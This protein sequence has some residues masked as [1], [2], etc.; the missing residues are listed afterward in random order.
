M[1]D[2]FLEEL[3]GVSAASIADARDERHVVLANAFLVAERA[4]LETRSADV[5]TA[6]ATLHHGG[7]D[8][9]EP[10]VARA[11]ESALEMA[12]LL[13]EGKYA[14][15]VRSE[16][17]LWL[18]EALAQR[19]SG[20]GAATS[21]DST[22][23]HL[24][25]TVAHALEQQLLQEEDGDSRLGAAYE[26][27]FVG[28]AL[29]SMYV[30]ANYT[31]PAFEPEQLHDIHALAA[32]FFAA[33]TSP[34]ADDVAAEKKLHS[35]ALVALQVD[36][37][38]PFA[39]CEYPQFLLLGRCLLHVVGNATHRNWSFAVGEA[40]NDSAAQDV[41]SSPSVGPEVLAVVSQLH[42]ASW[43]NARA[44]V[45][46]ERL[47]LTKE[48]SNTLWFEARR[49]FRRA[50]RQSALFATTET[51][52]YL[53]VRLEV[54][55]GLAQHH[56]DKN[57]QGK[58]SFE[59]AKELSGVSVQLSGSMGKRT[60]FQQKST[61]Q[62]VLLAASK[63]PPTDGAPSV[64]ATA[65][66]AS[67]HADFG[68]KQEPQVDDGLDGDGLTAAERELQRLVATGEASY[69]A[70]SL[71]QVDQDNILHEHIAF[72]DASLTAQGNLQVV[73]QVLLLALCL[74]VKNSNAND[75]LTREEMVPYVTRVLE[76][77]N[78]WMVYSTALLERAW[79]ECETSKRRERA[80]LQMQALVD[81][82]T[83]R[84]T[85]TQNSLAAIADAAP[86][87]ERL[88]FV[89]ALAFPPRYAL[90][91]DLAER[92]LAI[93]VVQSAL[94]IFESLEMW[95]DVV[96]CYQLL[97]KPL[98]AEK[99][100]R[101][102]LTV[103]PTPYMWCCLGDVTRDVTHYETAWTLS[104]H[105]FARAKRSLGRHCFEAGEYDAA[106]AHYQASVDV[107]PMHTS[108]WFVL[109]TMGMR[110]ERWSLAL[111]AFTRVAQLDP[112][113]G[114]AWGNIGSIHMHHGRYVDAFAVLQEALKQKRYMWQMWENYAVCAME[115]H[116]YGEAI[117]A[118]HQ[119]LDL[120]EKHARPVDHEVLAWLVEAIVFPEKYDRLVEDLRDAAS[121]SGENE[122]ENEDENENEDDDDLGD[123]DEATV[124]P[125]RTP[126]RSNVNL[127][128][129]LALLLGRITSIT[130]TNA[131]VWQ[132]Y[133]HFNDGLGR[134]E[135]AL[136]CR[137][138]QC[139]ALQKA[140]WEQDEA[141]VRELSKAA[142]RLA[143]DYVR[144]GSKKSLYACRLYL[145]GVLKKAQVDYAALEDVQA[146]AATLERVTGMEVEA[147]QR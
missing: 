118:L 92:Y 26:V 144:E 115:T 20:G 127:K 91:R 139:R 85:I 68:G 89:H 32:R 105:R 146:L 38:S 16:R 131:K 6:V 124:A 47:L 60:K 142:G 2:D 114:E 102:R 17:G 100:I 120:R 138:K 33:S 62:L 135:K 134:S 34:T 110:L 11:A 112:E 82:H 63:L 66:A 42:S 70:I 93:G 31:G 15:I 37:E 30:Q 122:V 78:N 123:L 51:A 56:F 80:L 25:T 130:T 52:A 64:Y 69:R 133:A 86:A 35:D 90:Q 140:G 4:V 14:D 108:A 109:G 41:V 128:K 57:K 132:I 44:A 96:K 45:A 19:V 143:E 23:Q 106:V 77:P 125:D 27:L 97:D 104:K 5:A 53:R 12:A 88:A 28:V 13:C 74:D 36:G 117:Y 98:R 99:L 7:A 81:Q 8:D 83:T 141:A 59:R 136:D 121:V 101:E 29:F 9:D 22:D 73:D 119:H 79:L 126:P 129:Q 111:Q 49:G 46:H 75:G 61:A 43:W 103:A 1:D 72:E 54:E 67:T 18:L 21:G 76:N 107:N 71:D 65:A 94:A 39:I 95:D 40:G 58:R 145:R 50:T 55:W 113:N 48:S 147:A 116:K 10:P 3:L 84:L 87:C 24:C 137:L